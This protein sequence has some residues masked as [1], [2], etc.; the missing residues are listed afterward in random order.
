[1]QNKYIYIFKYYAA[2]KMPGD[3]GERKKETERERKRQKKKSII[4]VWVI[5]YILS[6]G[7][8]VTGVL[9]IF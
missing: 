3:D 5:I 8:E 2:L 1:M 4:Y 6:L 7:C 9:S